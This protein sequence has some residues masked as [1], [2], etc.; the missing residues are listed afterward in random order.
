[1]L[2]PKEAKAVCSGAGAMDA[3]GPLFAAANKPVPVPAA[4]AGIGAG[5]DLAASPKVKPDV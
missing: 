4:K 2:P 1:M 5:A 3:K